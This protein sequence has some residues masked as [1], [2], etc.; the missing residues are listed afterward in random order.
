[1]VKINNNA[2]SMYKP[3]QQFAQIHF[4]YSGI[5][6]LQIDQ[7]GLHVFVGHIFAGIAEL[8]DDTVLNFR[9]G[10]YGFNGSGKADQIIRAGDEN[11]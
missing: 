11:G 4:V 9:F 6:R 10:K 5:D 8:M 1:M 3:R 2:L 7:K